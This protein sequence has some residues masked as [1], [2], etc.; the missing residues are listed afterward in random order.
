MNASVDALQGPGAAAVFVGNTAAPNPDL[1][2]EE[3]TT[4]NV[5]FTVSPIDQLEISL[6]YYNV[7]YDDR[8]VQENG[9][10]I[11]SAE[12]TA[13]L[14]AGCTVATLNTAVCQALRDP[15]VVRDSNT[16]AVSRIFT[17]RFN[18]ASAETDGFDLAASYFFD[19]NI[20]TFGI[21]NQTTFRQQ[22]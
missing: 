21:S 17:E 2:P 20:G 14:D 3:A 9:Q 11:L 19:S 18:A 4:F 16:G 12:T 6:D 8:L 15:A 22:L 10:A 5:G 7:E 13:L 1:I